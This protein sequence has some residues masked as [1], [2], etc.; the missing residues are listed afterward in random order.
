MDLH[1][2]EPKRGAKNAFLFFNHYFGPCFA[3]QAAKPVMFDVA[4]THAE[5]FASNRTACRPVEV[6]KPVATNEG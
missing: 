2:A 6:V 5:L 1:H 3:G 4:M